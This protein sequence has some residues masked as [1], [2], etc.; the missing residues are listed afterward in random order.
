MLPS[1][2]HTQLGRFEFQA[3]YLRWKD[4][5]RDRSTGVGS[6]FTSIIDV[7]CSCMCFLTSS[8]ETLPESL[9]WTTC[10]SNVLNCALRVEFGIF[11]MHDLR[12]YYYFTYLERFCVE[13]GR[14]SLHRYSPTVTARLGAVV[15]PIVLHAGR[16]DLR[17]R[18][19]EL[20]RRAWMD[21]ISLP[22]FRRAC[23][24]ACRRPNP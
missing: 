23:H 4:S 3:G 8:S 14:S 13:L 9:R 6:P 16:C 22:L 1:V 24:S 2:K 15:K 10:V 17:R 19:E 12:R 18:P 21:E 11:E 5:L 20:L 7:S